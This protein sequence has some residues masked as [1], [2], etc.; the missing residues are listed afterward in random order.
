MADFDFENKPNGDP[1][2]WNYFF[3]MVSDSNA[4]V[5]KFS[6]NAIGRR[7][8]SIK[9]DNITII[10]PRTLEPDYVDSSNRSVKVILYE[11]LESVPIT[12]L[13]SFT[14]TANTSVSATL[15]M[16]L[17]VRVGD[18]LTVSS[19]VNNQLIDLPAGLLGNFTVAS[20]GA[21]STS[22]T[23]A[24]S[25]NVTNGTYYLNFTRNT[26]ATA[27]ARS[28]TIDFF[29]GTETFTKNSSIVGS[30]IPVGSYVS[31]VDT[32][33]ANY[34]R[35]TIRPT[36]VD[37]QIPFNTPFS[38]SAVNATL[39]Q[40]SLFQTKNADALRIEAEFESLEI[41]YVSIL[42]SQI[43]DNLDNQE[44]QYKSDAFSTM[45]NLIYLHTNFNESIS[46]SS[47]P[48][49]FLEPNRKITVVDRTTGISGEH[50]LQ[51][52][53]IPLSN[54]GTMNLSAIKIQT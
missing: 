46:V 52:F 48:I 7:I 6:V 32:S 30:G 47:I 27:N 9:D 33:N 53:D 41:P 50:Y 20:V 39:S 35:L 29:N 13:Y 19:A 23:F 40:Y 3:D 25:T 14:V 12:D 37:F 51:S 34:T 1:F 2:S 10:Y 8:K 31:F 49:Y 22:F 44:F 4:A 38:F 16:P 5:G 43:V 17:D 11:D 28:T 42:K 24:T 36:G 15:T 18:R 26:Y 45:K 54:E 21:N